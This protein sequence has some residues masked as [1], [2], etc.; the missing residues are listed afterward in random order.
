M[1]RQSSTFELSDVGAPRFKF[2]NGGNSLARFLFMDGAVDIDGS[3]RFT[4]R[5][6]RCVVRASLG[7]TNGVI[8]KRL[9]DFG[10]YT[11]TRD[12]V[13][14]LTI[15]QEELNINTRQELFPACVRGGIFRIFRHGDPHLFPVTESQMDIIS[16]AAQGNLLKDIG[17]LLDPPLS[18]AAVNSRLSNVKS[19]VGFGNTALFV[20]SAVITQQLDPTTFEVNLAAAA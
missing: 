10:M 14:D 12:V 13:K 4:E 9:S 7:Q 6:K 1:P 18:K 15:V 11:L 3:D 2:S 5:E 8:A 16:L 19:N 17:P 20:T